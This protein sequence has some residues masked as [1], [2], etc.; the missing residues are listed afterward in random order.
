MGR[1]YGSRNPNAIM[2]TN[3]FCRGSC[4]PW[5]MSNARPKR[6]ISLRISKAVT[7]I[8]RGSCTQVLIACVGFDKVRGT[9]RTGTFAIRD[10]PRLSHV[11]THGNDENGDGHEQCR[12]EKESLGRD[13]VKS[14]GRQTQ[15]EKSHRAFSQP[16]G[17]D[18]HDVAS[19][20]VLVT[21]PCQIAIGEPAR[22]GGDG[23][24][25]LTFCHCGSS[26]SGISA[27][28]FP[29]PLDVAAKTMAA[30]IMPNT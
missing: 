23:A 14:I 9:N 19:V 10:D 4:S 27:R 16:H 30:C 5:T 6:P 13:D 1:T 21:T 11:A 7:A 17:D 28:V 2:T 22:I 18:V 26:A 12:R 24:S 20:E 3:F 8:H 25:A 15:K 29:K